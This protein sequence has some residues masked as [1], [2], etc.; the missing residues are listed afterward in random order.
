MLL[1]A[2]HGR[3]TSACASSLR[4]PRQRELDLLAG[5]LPSPAALRQLAAAGFTTILLHHRGRSAYV[6]RFRERLDGQEE[7]LL[8][9]V[10]SSER[11]TAYAIELP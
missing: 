9:E 1:S 2:Y 4:T 10:H 7:R 6:D 5:E 11:A 3:R 8:R